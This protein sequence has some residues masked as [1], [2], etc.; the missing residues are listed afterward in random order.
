M[1]LAMGEFESHGGLMK[2]IKRFVNAIL[3]WLDWESVYVKK[4]AGVETVKSFGVL[5][6]ETFAYKGKHVVYAIGGYNG[7]TFRVA[8]LPPGE[9]KE[10]SE[11]ENASYKMI[12]D[13]FLRFCRGFEGKV[14]Y[15]HNLNFDGQFL[16]Q[17]LKKYAIVEV[18]ILNTN[19]GYS[20][21]G[22]DVVKGKQYSL[23]ALHT[24]FPEKSLKVSLEVFLKRFKEGYNSCRRCLNSSMTKEEEQVNN[25]KRNIIECLTIADK[26]GKPIRVRDSLKLLPYSLRDLCKWVGVEHQKG[27]FPYG[28]VNE[29]T[30]YYE[31][32]PPDREY[33]V[34]D[35]VFVGPGEFS[36]ERETKKY[37]ELDCKGLYEVLIKFQSMI[38]SKSQVDITEV[39]SV[40]G[41]AFRIFCKE[42]IGDCKKVIYR[43]TRQ[44]DREIRQGYFGGSTQVFLPYM[45]GELYYYDINSLYPSCMLEDMPSLV[46]EIKLEEFFGFVECTIFC[47]AWIKYPI[48]PV[49]IDS[50]V[51]AP[52]GMLEG[53]W[54][55]EE[56]KYAVSMGYSIV[57]VKRGW[58]FER[59]VGL[60]SEYVTKYYN[61]RMASDN[62]FENKMYK[63]ILNG[64]YGKMGQNTRDRRNMVIYQDDL[65]EI[66]KHFEINVMKAL[67]V[68]EELNKYGLRKYQVEFSFKP[69]NELEE[70]DYV[71]ANKLNKWNREENQRMLASVAIGAAVSSYGRI[72]QYE[73]I[74]KCEDRICYT[75]T[76]SFVIHGEIGVSLGEGLGELRLEGKYDEGYFLAPKIYGM[77]SKTGEQ[78]NRMSGIPAECIS[79]EDYKRFYDN[80]IK[81]YSWKSIRIERGEV[82]NMYKDV[83]INPKDIVS[84]RVPIYNE[85]GQW[86]STR[87]YSSEELNSLKGG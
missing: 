73:I 39:N 74:N 19:D 52:T 83:T 22:L 57:K 14:I 72:R 63:W 25:I 71:L 53:V 5:D 27:Y 84:K 4:V 29:S 68:G 23:S 16:L 43:L 10:F 2:L 66:G 18:N 28:F 82:E 44:E 31:G 58:K 75:D 60:F 12:A 26:R 87:P 78:R 35:N 40:A 67:K 38:F 47:P 7:K 24:V 37:L 8:Y 49:R 51:G 45:K 21:L 48:L 9:Y 15:C 77:I 56:I 13:F 42:G 76:D 3:S 55:S 11:F 32:E 20:I 6:M 1:K 54:F 64:L 80:E 65:E 30:L 79:Y 86:V 46:G 85:K 33:Y 62:K 34:D 69:T 41:L 36:V 61:A 70:A 50:W 81:I 59:G 17:A